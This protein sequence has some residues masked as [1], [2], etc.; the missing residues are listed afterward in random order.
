MHCIEGLFPI[1]ICTMN[2]W[3]SLAFTSTAWT[4]PILMYAPI[5]F[6]FSMFSSK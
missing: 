6:Y 3:T 1:M 5:M 4:K 2:L